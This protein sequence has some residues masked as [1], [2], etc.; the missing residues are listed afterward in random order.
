MQWL[1]RND[2]PPAKCFFS[3]GTLPNYVDTAQPPT[4]RKPFTT[5]VDQRW[6]HTVQMLLPVEL[7]D[8]VQ[9]K[10]QQLAAGF[11][12]AKVKMSLSGLISGEFFG[13]YIKKGPGDSS[14]LYGGC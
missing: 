14:C 12:Y 11:C 4:R 2:T 6:S 5:I 3:H 10:I 1:A 8:F 13:V 7:L 9:Q